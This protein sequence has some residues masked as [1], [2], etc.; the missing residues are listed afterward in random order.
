ML[1]P[2]NPLS[3]KSLTI[4]DQYGE[5]SPKDTKD[6]DFVVAYAHML[7][8][9]E[10]RFFLKCLEQDCP[11]AYKKYRKD[12]DLSKKRAN[13][14][15]FKRI[16]ESNRERAK[17]EDDFRKAWPYSKIENEI[18]KITPN[19]CGILFTSNYYKNIEFRDSLQYVAGS[20]Q[21]GNGYPLSVIL[22]AMLGLFRQLKTRK[23]LSMGMDS[24]S[25][26][27]FYLCCS[28]E[29][30]SDEI[31]RRTEFDKKKKQE[32]LSRGFVEMVTP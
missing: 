8:G 32:I 24:F 22:P 28:P 20:L 13:E 18:R 6:I 25:E 17:Q 23:I 12:E 2:M 21:G 14:Q 19:A 15:F 9:I 26:E 10:K 31:R 27:Q 29:D 7:E 16:A 3:D 11:C 1:Y 4:L 30:R 5:L